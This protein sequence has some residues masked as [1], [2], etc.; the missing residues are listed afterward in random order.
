MDATRSERAD[1]TWKNTFAGPASNGIYRPRRHRRSG[2]VDHG[3]L[4]LTAW[5]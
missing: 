4:G 5:A 2:R 1:K 3:A